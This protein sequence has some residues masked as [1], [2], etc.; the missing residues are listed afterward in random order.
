MEFSFTH[1]TSASTR[2]QGSKTDFLGYASLLLRQ[3][4]KTRLISF[5]IPQKSMYS[6]YSP[7]STCHFIRLG[8]SNFIDLYDHRYILHNASGPFLKY[9]QAHYNLAFSCMNYL[10]SSECFLNESITLNERALRVLK[11]FHGLHQ[12]A[13]EFWFRHLLQYAK[14]GIVVDE[15]RLEELLDEIR[16]F[17]KDEPGKGTKSLT[18]EDKN[19]PDHIEVELEVLNTLPQAQSMLLDLLR[20]RQFLSQEKYAHQKAESEPI[21][22]CHN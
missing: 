16:V 5:T 7:C 15:D 4:Q 20:F 2:D 19:S 21:H 18:L 1:K 17:W 22:L 10:I 13:N 11:G 6:F 9:H 8:G 3:G 12:Y 14:F